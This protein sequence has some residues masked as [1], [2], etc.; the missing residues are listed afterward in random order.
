MQTL[1][2]DIRYGLRMLG[3]KP[4]FTIVALITV[5]LGIGANTAIFSVVNGVLLRSLPYKDADRILTLW[6]SDGQTGKKEDGAAPANFLDWQT[7]NQVFEQMA[8]VEPYSFRLTSNAEPES[9]RAWLV[10]EGFFDILGVPPLYGRSFLPEE[11]QAG[12]NRVIVIGESLWRGRFGADP[13]LVGQSLIFNGQPHTIVG[14]MP[15]SFQMPSGRVMWSPLVFNDSY[16]QDRRSTYMKVVARLK[17]GVS[18]EQAQQEMSGI[19]ARLTAQYPQ[20]NK[21]RGVLV[22]PLA[23]QMTGEARPALLLLLGAAGFVLLIACANVA[24]LLL[25]RGS[26]RQKEFAIRAALGAVR[27]RLVRQLITESATLALLGGVGGVLLAWWDVD[28]VLA[29]SPGNLPRLTEI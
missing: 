5:T 2:Q 23:E 6:E 17:A 29:L 14:I 27:L 8:T 13:N 21:G 18:R 12:N 22:I 9:F 15:A 4:G 25:A 3:R 28:M 7:Q 1:W 24:N 20:S 26:E 19:Q 11:Y 10:T 16:R